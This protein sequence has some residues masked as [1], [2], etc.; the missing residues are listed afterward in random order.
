MVIQKVVGIQLRIS[1]GLLY[2]RA[3][4]MEMWECLETNW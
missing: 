4:R 3:K 2:D 1:E